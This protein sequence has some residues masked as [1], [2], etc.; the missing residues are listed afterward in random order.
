MK[1]FF[2]WSGLIV[3]ALVAVSFTSCATGNTITTVTPPTAEKVTTTPSETP[4]V[5]PEA[6]VTTSPAELSEQVYTNKNFGYR[7]TL[8]TG[9]TAWVDSSSTKPY[10]KDKVVICNEADQEFA[11]IYTPMLET[12]AE[13]WEPIEEKNL[14]VP[15]STTVLHT[16]KG[17]P[18]ADSGVAD[19][20]YWVSW[21]GAD[22][23]FQK[24]GLIMFSYL[25]DQADRLNDFESM[26]K[27]LRFL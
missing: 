2:I 3:A 14:I 25:P 11:T 27:S 21:R 13:I 16:W 1:K 19:W 22:D 18:M 15:G 9:Y 24:T 26:I 20:V 23:D 7:M 10:S 12:G 17:K 6:S 5:S 8:P 4:T